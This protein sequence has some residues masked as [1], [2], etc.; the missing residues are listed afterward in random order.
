[1][2]QTLSKKLKRHAEENE[3][4]NEDGIPLKFVSLHPVLGEKRVKVAIKRLNDFREELEAAKFEL[5]QKRIDLV[6]ARNTS[7][8]LNADTARRD[9]S[10]ARATLEAATAR[11]AD[12]EEELAVRQASLKKLE[13]RV[14]AKIADARIRH[15]GRI[16]K[17]IETQARR[18]TAAQFKYDGEKTRLAELENEVQP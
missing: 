2:G 9:A 15:D 6:S 5:A 8:K 14:N 1:M 12:L 4:V 18:V 3:I 17:R 7:S 11:V 10:S 13:A 16:R